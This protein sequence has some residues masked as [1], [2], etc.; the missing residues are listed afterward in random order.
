MEFGIWNDCPIRFVSQVLFNSY[1]Y[2]GFSLET[3]MPLLTLNLRH[4]LL[5]PL[6][7]WASNQVR[8]HNPLCLNGGWRTTKPTRITTSPQLSKTKQKAD[9]PV[10]Q[11]LQAAN[12]SSSIFL[13]SLTG[14]EHF[15]FPTN[16]LKTRRFN[17]IFGTSILLNSQLFLKLKFLVSIFSY[18]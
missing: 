3:C 18:L 13:L 14:S 10:D 12:P 17:C 11:T 4:L 8:V 15:R 2:P 6:L 1:I 7:T 9:I 5:K 16:Q